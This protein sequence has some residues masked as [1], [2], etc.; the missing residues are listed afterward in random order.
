[1]TDI[2]FIPET[3]NLSALDLT[4]S[5]LAQ[6]IDHTKLSAYATSKD[7]KELCEDALKY[8]FGAVC[9]N[10]V[11]VKSSYNLLDGSDTE[12][13]TVI[14]FP[15]G[16]NT[17]KIKAAEAELALSHGAKE[18]DMV[19]NLQRVRDGDWEGVAHDIGV[20]YDEVKGNGIL[21][22]ILETGY[23]TRDQIVKACEMSVEAGA[24]FVKTSTGFGVMGATYDHVKLMRET[25]GPDIGVK[26]SGGIRDVKSAIYMIEAGASRLGTSSGVAILK[27]LSWLKLTKSWI[28]TPNPCPHCPSRLADLSSMSSSTYRWYKK[29]CFGCPNE[30]YN[31]FN[32]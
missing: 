12:V 27:G 32:D 28:H 24:D 3:I 1:M 13:C 20:L 5:K 17:P 25:V 6:M 22:V 19:I 26:A 18:I 10:P 29:Q 30:Q 4:E 2:F 21:K 16:A 7:I 11:H 15:L 31:I 14:G 23:L 9:I 8:N